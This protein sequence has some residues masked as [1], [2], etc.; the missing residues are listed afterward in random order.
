MML[1][2]LRTCPGDP[3]APLPVPELVLV[4]RG[5]ETVGPLPRALQGRHVLCILSWSSE[6]AGSTA[7][8]SR[9]ARWS[10]PVQTAAS[11]LLIKL[12]SSELPV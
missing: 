10:Q 11:A 1:C 12:E 2:P 5:W 8:W 9:P 4:W 6:C 7:R 3:R